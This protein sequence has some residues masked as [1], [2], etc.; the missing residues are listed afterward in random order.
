MKYG[1]LT[2]GQ[3]EAVMNKL[4][5]ME[6][7]EKFLRGEVE[8][9][10]TKHLINCSA[11][12]LIPNNWTV[13]E[14]QKGG[15]FEWNPDSLTL[16][17]SEEQK[18]KW[19]TGRTLREELKGKPVL[20]ACV[21]DYLLAHPEIIPKE[22]KGKAVFFWGTIY[23]DSGGYLSVCYLC[24]SGDRWDWD[25]S[26][27]GEDW[28]AAGPALLLASSPACRQGGQV[29]LSGPDSLISESGPFSSLDSH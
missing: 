27:L 14:H 8:V 2:L 26:W 10:V 28:G 18:Q 23:R 20:N 11:D 22:W 5:G 21:L 12:P 29:V 4:G 9:R 17:L 15:E 24:W 13:E 16:Y 3:V 1:T 25:R 19:V 7:V 6:G